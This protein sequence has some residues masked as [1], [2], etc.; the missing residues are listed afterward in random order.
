M[1]RRGLHLLSG[2]V[3]TYGPAVQKGLK[4]EAS[5]GWPGSL[6]LV[7]KVIKLKKFA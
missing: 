1:R 6:G 3:T 2:D 4:A 5:I 7:A